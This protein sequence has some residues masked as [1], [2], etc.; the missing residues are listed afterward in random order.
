[1]ELRIYA[2]DQTVLDASK[3]IFDVNGWKVLY[4]CWICSYFYYLKVVWFLSFSYKVIYSAN[5]I[6]LRWF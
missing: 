2:V 3:K 4:F 6:E 5:N 1:M